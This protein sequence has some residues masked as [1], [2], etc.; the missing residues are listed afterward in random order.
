MTKIPR[1]D[2]QQ[3]V[4]WLASGRP[5]HRTYRGPAAKPQLGEAA[6]SP[7]QAEQAIASAGRVNPRFTTGA[8][9]L[10][11][12]GVVGAAVDTGIAVNNVTSAPPEQRTEVAVNEV[13]RVG[14]AVGGGWAGATLGA[15]AGLACGPA[16]PVCS[17]V[18]ALIGGALGAW[19]GGEAG[20]AGAEY[21][22]DQA[23]G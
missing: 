13:G 18:G 4:P 11:G 5:K 16:A 19:G 21:V 10:R 9:L 6:L 1:F 23:A 20:E 12:A 17:P 8:R 2:E 14:G 7:R 22:Y 3:N 15:S